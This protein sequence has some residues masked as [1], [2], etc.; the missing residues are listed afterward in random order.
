MDMNKEQWING[1]KGMEKMIGYAKES[2][3][4]C[5]TEYR[6]GKKNKKKIQ[7]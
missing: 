7:P 4:T 5:T 3:C 6:N 1:N 2:D